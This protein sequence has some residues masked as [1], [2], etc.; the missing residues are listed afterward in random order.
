MSAFATALKKSLEI[1]FYYYRPYRAVPK[2]S[3]GVSAG[4]MKWKSRCAEKRLPI[5]GVTKAFYGCDL[6]KNLVGAG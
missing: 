6:G 2:I 1:E 3:I 5:S 4:T